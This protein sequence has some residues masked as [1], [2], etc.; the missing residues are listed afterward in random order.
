MS[1]RTIVD[2]VLFR[3]ETKIGKSGKPYAIA[4]VREKTG[5]ESRWWRVFIFGDEMR[6]E[7]SR[8]SAG[9][10]I[11]VAGEFGADI[12]APEGREARVSLTLTADGI[13]SAHKPR[14][15]PKAE[16]ADPPTAAS[17]AT[18]A[19]GGALVDDDIPF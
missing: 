5:G 14:A 15:A 2:G 4:T 19:R 16:R 3:A 18:P 13:L 10:P 12:W 8:L 17:R 6:D 7:V 9:E 11:A 1:A